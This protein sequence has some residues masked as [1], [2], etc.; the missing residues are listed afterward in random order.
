MLSQTTYYV[1]AMHTFEYGQCNGSFLQKHYSEK[2][3]RRISTRGTYFK[4]E[5]GEKLLKH[6]A[7]EM[8]L[9][10]FT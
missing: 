4:T 1:A 8:H 7:M 10:I 5:G 2:A 3:L 9:V 6:M